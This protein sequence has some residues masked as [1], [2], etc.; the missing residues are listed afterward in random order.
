MPM[1]IARVI[2]RELRPGQV[3]AITGA[4]IR[5]TGR[6]ELVIHGVVGSNV[7]LSSL[8]AEFLATA[9]AE[10]V[11]SVR[12]VPSETK[13]PILDRLNGRDEASLKSRDAD[14]SGTD[15]GDAAFVP[16]ARARAVLRGKEIAAQDLLESG[17]S[18]SLEDVRKLF[19]GVTRQSIEKR[20]RDG[21]ML[22]VPGPNNKRFYP[23]AQFTDD[24]AVVEGLQALAKA[25]RTEN[26]LAILNFLVNPSSPLDDA[27][28]I[29]LL[30]NGEVERV[31]EAAESYGEQGA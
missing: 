14:R 17:G 2:S 21:K 7:R 4:L 13:V 23:V 5:W 29:D 20:V 28:P 27:K 12:T 11:L 24:G 1:R 31:V 22:A 25:L 8:V 9:L 15:I 26:G 3:R 30:R 16:S 18:Y 6:G 10:P 19:N